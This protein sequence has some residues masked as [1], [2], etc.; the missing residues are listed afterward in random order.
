MVGKET[1]KWL[2]KRLENGWEG[3]WKLVGKKA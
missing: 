2:V 3:D 1:G